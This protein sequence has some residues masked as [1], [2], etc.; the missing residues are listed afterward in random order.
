MKIRNL[1]DIDFFLLLAAITLTV[2]GVLFIYSSGMSSTGVPVS[3]EYIKQIIWGISGLILALVLAMVDYQRLLGLSLYF[4]LGTLGLLT[5]TCIFG[6]TVNG[7][8]AWIG[9]GS[10]GIQPS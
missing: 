1:L 10:F 2:F 9:I 6:H 5:Y 3:T 7:A 4:Y 8:R